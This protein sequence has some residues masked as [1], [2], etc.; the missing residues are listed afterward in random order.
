MIK[1]QGVLPGFDSQSIVAHDGDVGVMALT[2][3]T[4]NALHLNPRVADC[5]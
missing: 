5:R 3:G 4:R 1:H 2:N